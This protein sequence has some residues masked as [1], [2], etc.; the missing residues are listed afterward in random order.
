VELPEEAAKIVASRPERELRSEALYCLALALAKDG[1]T[2]HEIL[3]VVEK[4]GSRWRTLPPVSRNR[5]ARYKK[6][7]QLIAAVRKRY[8][9]HEEAS[10]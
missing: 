3:V 8:P 1:W 7:M 2:N 6:L 5:F 4:Y 9:S 10:E